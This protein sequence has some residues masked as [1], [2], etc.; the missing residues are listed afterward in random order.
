[1][2]IFTG[3]LSFLSGGGSSIVGA[4]SGALKGRTERKQQAAAAAAKIKLLQAGT[5][6][7]VQ[8]TDLDIQR[9]RVAQGE[10]SWK[11]EYALLLITLPMI[12]I[13]LEALGVPGI[14]PGSGQKMVDAISALL[15]DTVEYGHLF[16]GAITA[17]LGLR[18]KRMG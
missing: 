12:V 8:L 14:E 13:M 3:L 1:M 15:G 17:S 2:G 7:Q 11:D 18:W 16:A 4:V 6:A 10:H 9:L 5:E